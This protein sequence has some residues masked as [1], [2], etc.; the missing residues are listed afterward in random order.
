MHYDAADKIVMTRILFICMGNICRSPTAEAVTRALVERAGLADVVE[1]D[2][3]GTH[4]YH[5]GEPP[6]RRATEAG[7]RRGYDLSRLRARQVG[8]SDYARFDLLLAM[9]KANLE[10]LQRNCPPDARNKLRLFLAYARRHR[11]EEV[12]D[13][14]YGGVGGFE[15]VLDLIE[16]AAE[17]LIDSLN[18][19]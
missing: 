1:L 7:A 3:A 9:D 12:P 13:P 11:E 18:P 6:D 5:V 8:S 16:D 15:R 10:S 2:S 17:G 14:Y 19:K 4:G